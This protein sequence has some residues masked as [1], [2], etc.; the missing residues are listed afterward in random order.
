M[1]LMMDGRK[2]EEWEISEQSRRAML[3]TQTAIRANM[4][5]IGIGWQ[6]ENFNGRSVY[7]HSGDNGKVMMCYAVGDAHRRRALV[8][9]TNGGAGD[10]IYERLIRAATG[11]DLLDF[12]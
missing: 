8:I 11:I 7:E 5:S 1:A 9:L 10:R 12:L 3:T 2:R 6:L 4:K